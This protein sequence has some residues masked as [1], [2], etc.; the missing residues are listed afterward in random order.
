MAVGEGN[1]RLVLI[2]KQEGETEP[3]NL[4]PVLC[5]ESWIGSLFHSRKAGFWLR[6]PTAGGT[7]RTGQLPLCKAWKLKASIADSAL[8]D[9][10]PRQT[11]AN[12]KPFIPPAENPVKPLFLISYKCL[13]HHN[14]GKSHSSVSIL[15]RP[16]KRR[17]PV[18]SFLSPWFSSRGVLWRLAWAEPPERCRSL[19]DFWTL[20]QRLGAGEGAPEPV[21]RLKIPRTVRESIF[22]VLD[23]VDDGTVIRSSRTEQ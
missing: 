2:W 22:P 13:L 21:Q 10:H 4:I 19:L 5:T 15:I 11:A 18:I 12:P 14:A 3:F 9:S 8:P 6:R 17:S 1:L 16:R 20:Q 7:G 23:K